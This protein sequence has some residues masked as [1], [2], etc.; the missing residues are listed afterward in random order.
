MVTTCSN[1]AAWKELP[2]P[3]TCGHEDFREAL[4]LSVRLQAHYASLLNMHD[5]GERIVFA[6]VDEWLARLRSGRTT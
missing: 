2:A 6:T 5:G 1:C 3:P 4:E